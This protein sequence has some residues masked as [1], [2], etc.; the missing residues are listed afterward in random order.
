MSLHLLHDLESLKQSLLGICAMVEKSV[1]LAVRALEAQDAK[2]A[3]EVIDGD[4][5]IDRRE[6]EIEEEALKILA[7]HQPVATDLRW[8]VAT[9]KI[10]NDLERIG[11]LAVNI[12]QRVER[13]AGQ[14]APQSR[15]DLGSM[16]EKV[17]AMLRDSLDSL[18]RMDVA[19]AWRVCEADDAV[20]AQNRQMYE[21]VRESLAAHPSD[22]DFL[23]H[24]MGVSRNLERVADH[25]T[26][27]AQDVIY[28][29]TGEIVRHRQLQPG[30]SSETPTVT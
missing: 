11:D 18:F 4:D 3:R 8:I 26:N 29:I 16:E 14:G 17:M 27:I 7:L 6:V 2:T 22:V 21:R 5:L 13:L 9:I 28:M 25:A 20:D 24:A 23:I 10:N 15:L 19:L 30:R 12:A 1:A